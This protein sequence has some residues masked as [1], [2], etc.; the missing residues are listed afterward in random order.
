MIHT[1][2][3]GGILVLKIS[4][5]AFV[6]VMIVLQIPELRYDLDSSSPVEIAS[7]EDLTR[8]RFPGIHFVSVAGK[9]DFEKAFVYQRYGLSFTYFHAQPYG[10]RLV[11]RSYDTPTEE[12]KRFERF[13][14][15]LRP[16][17]RQPF[18]YKIRDIHR[19]LF[20]ME[21]PEDA[22]FLGLDDVPRLS[23]WQVGGVSFAGLLWGGMLYAFFLR[24]V[25]ARRFALRFKN[26]EVR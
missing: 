11:I 22:F 19:D 24:R 12:W 10:M 18:S 6:A 15:K 4:I 25:A 7:P 13:L 21:I 8:E 26:R 1:L 16:F 17:D 3:R 9:A 20:Q 14:G 23:G 2:V 5:L